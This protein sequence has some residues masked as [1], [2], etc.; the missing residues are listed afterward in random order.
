MQF[1]EN[2]TPLSMKISGACRLPVTLAGTYSS[3][4]SR[5]RTLP[6]TLPPLMITVPASISASISRA[7]SDD[8]HVR[9]L[10]L[11][12]EA[13]V[14]ANAPFEGQLALEVSASAEQRRDLGGGK[15]GVH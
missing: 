10:D 12:F 8:E 11:A 13:A 7:L 2:C 4:L 14:D 3:M 6:V 15:S 9:A 5:A 1:P